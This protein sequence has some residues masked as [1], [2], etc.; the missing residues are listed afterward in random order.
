MPPRT[1]KASV[2]PP[3]YTFANLDTMITEKGKELADELMK[4]A[5]GRNPEAFDMYVYND[6]YGYGVI[7]L[8]DD[9]LATL[10][11]KN[12]KKNYDDAY[13]LL[14][15]VTL[16]MD[17]ESYAWTGIDDGDHVRITNKAY[18]ALA[19]AVMR[20]L[21]KTGRLSKESF[22]SLE[23]LLRNIIEIG[24]MLDGVGCESEYRLPIR[25]I[26][27]RLF[28]D[29]TKEDFALEQKQR[30]EWV[31]GIK[32]KEVKKKLT[33]A[34]KDLV[35]EM[36]EETEPWYMKGPILD[37]DR[38]NSEYSLNPV[39]KEYKAFLGP[40]NKMYIVPRDMAVGW[41]IGE[42]SDKA[43]AQYSYAAMGDA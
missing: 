10:N 40:R 16:F 20:G 38:R 32:D 24:D 18:G 34:L 43:R 35:K 17:E 5:D 23:C 25:A 37:E 30:E 39:Y 41:D 19:V 9:T 22:P 28:K 1:P 21:K 2:I 3:G 13:P 15:A 33:S 31:K 36:K 14:E 42:W 12:A 26:A 8:I 4:K 27:R 29:K 11:T 7:D 6:F